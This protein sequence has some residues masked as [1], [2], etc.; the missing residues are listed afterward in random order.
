MFIA[1]NERRPEA[2]FRP[3]MMDGD[4]HVEILSAAPEP[5]T[6]ITQPMTIDVQLAYTVT[7]ELVPNDISLDIGLR[8]IG[9]NS[10][11]VPP[12]YFQQIDLTGYEG[13]VSVL[14]H[15]RPEQVAIG[16]WMLRD[17]YAMGKDRFGIPALETSTRYSWCIGCLPDGQ[18]I[19]IDKQYAI[20]SRARPQLAFAGRTTLADD[21]CIQTQ[22]FASDLPAA[23]WPTD[24]CSTLRLGR[25]KMIVPLLKEDGPDELRPNVTYRLQA[26]T[27]ADR[28]DLVEKQFDGLVLEPNRAFPSGD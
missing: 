6:T 7:R 22:L 27:K 28:A 14:L 5:G 24:T 17:I 15:V 26:W 2:K 3:D 19:A 18:N 10:F 21:A 4:V 9:I 16:E 13:T 20:G 25:W 12:S 11:G 23:W 1:D 8:P